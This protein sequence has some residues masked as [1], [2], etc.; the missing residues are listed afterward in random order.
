MAAR[1]IADRLAERRRRRG[2]EPLLTYY[3]LRSGERTELS[4]VT[5][6]N[7]VDKTANL[8]LDEYAVAPGEAVGL[9]LAAEAPGH[10]MTAVWEL[11]CWQVT[12]VVEVGDTADPAR[13]AVAGPSL[14]FG[15]PEPV[16][17]VACSLSPLG[18]PF[19]A[20]LPA[21]V[22]DYSGEVRG[23][24]DSAPILPAGAATPAWVDRERRL[25]HAD[26]VAGAAGPPRRILVQPSDPWT[27]CRTGVLAALLSG[28]STVIV[29]GGDPDQVAALAASE[30]AEPA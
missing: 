14:D 29:V 10:W 13:L 16:D 5:L 6:A 27:T 11:A 1:W 9:P 15:Q 12:A 7:W 18:L 30:R 23:Q 22:V 24:P 19:T 4:A 17:R 26:L 28:G 25:S 21:G 8:L 3:D 2:A 20:A